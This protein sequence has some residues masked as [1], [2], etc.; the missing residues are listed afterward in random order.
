MEDEIAPLPT[1]ALPPEVIRD[2]AMTPVPEPVPEPMALADSAPAPMAPATPGDV[3]SQ[4]EPRVGPE[5]PKSQVIAE[6]AAPAK[7]PAY[8]PPPLPT[9]AD[10]DAHAA[11]IAQDFATGA[12]HPKTF[13]ELIPQ[14]TLGKIGAY[15]GLMLSSMGSGLSGQPNAVLQM[16]DKTINNDLESQKAS[17]ANLLESQKAGAENKKNLYALALQHQQTITAQERAHWEN[18]LSEAQIKKIPSEIA[19]NKAQLRNLDLNNQTLATAN[20]KATMMLGAANQLLNSTNTMAEGPQKQQG[21]LAINDHVKPGVL[22]GIQVESAKAAGQIQL[23]NALLPPDPYQDE[24]S[25]QDRQKGLTML[26]MTDMRDFETKRHM[27]GISGQASGELTEKDKE[28]ARGATALIATLQRL[29]Q[30]AKDHPKPAPNSPEDTYG[31]SLAKQ[32]Q[33]DF[34]VATNGGTYKEGESKFIDQI[35]PEDPTTWSPFEN[36]D[37][38]INALLD[39]TKTRHHGFIKSLGF[40]VDGEPERL[41]P[42]GKKDQKPQEL[43]LKDPKTGKKAIFDAKTKKFLRYK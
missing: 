28:Q 42:N 37:A 20:T 10:L 6:P 19:Y 27:P 17:A 2:N 4:I 25:F 13:K 3:A 31:K 40:P 24:K 1:E 11:Q 29:K 41:G 39:E 38:K 8:V 35:V 15:F 43:I 26:G 32:A 30:F 9:A 34:R 16:M 23:R 22:K 12:I 5:L 21:L 36:V 18:K 33:T 7:E 14:D